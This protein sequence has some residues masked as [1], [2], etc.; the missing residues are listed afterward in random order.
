MPPQ[1]LPVKTHLLALALSR[2]GSM[3][4]SD[5]NEHAPRIKHLHAAGKFQGAIPRPRTADQDGLQALL[6]AQLRRVSKLLKLQQRRAVLG[7][8][9]IIMHQH[10]ATVT[11]ER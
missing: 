11:F 5:S 9:G 8:G 10:A 3:N 2:L 6:L 1:N 4:R 7:I